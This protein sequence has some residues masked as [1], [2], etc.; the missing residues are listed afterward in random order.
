MSAR[1]ALNLDRIAQTESLFALSNGHIG[2]RGNLEEGEPHGLPGT[3]LNGFYETRPLPYAEIGF[4]VSRGRAVD[5]RRHQRQDHPTARRRRA[6]RCAVRR[7]VGTRTGFGHAGRHPRSRRAVEVACGQ[8]GARAVDPAGFVGAAQRG[9]HRVRRR[10]DRRVRARHR[11]VRTRRQRRPAGTIE[12]PAG[13]DPVAGSAGGGPSRD[14]RAWGV[15]RAQDPGQWPDDGRGD[16]SRRRRTGPGRGQ[17]RGERG[18]GPHDRHLRAAARPAA[19][20]REVSG[21]RVVEPAL[22]PRAA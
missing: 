7:I 3:Y 2:L 10:G 9:R 13:R 11:A 4:L 17:H 12:G 15:A 16:G 5:R 1:P 21:V 14:H 19:A 22:T 8:A 6:V 18:S 20:H